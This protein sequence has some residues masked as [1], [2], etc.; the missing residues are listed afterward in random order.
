MAGPPSAPTAAVANWSLAASP[1]CTAPGYGAGAFVGPL[2]LS[3]GF[4]GGVIPAGWSVET[5]SGA[6]WKV[7]TGVEPCSIE[8]RTGG[9]GPYAMVNSGCEGPADTFLVTPT[10][11]LSGRTSAAIQWANDYITD[12]FEPS[13]VSVDVSDDGGSNWTNVWTRESNVPGPGHQIADMSFAAGHANVA[14]RFHYQGFFSRTWQVDDVKV[15]SSRA[16]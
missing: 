8:N 3:E 12:Q 14:V 15:G 5:V 4:D 7:Y 2:A 11:D 9:S 13:V 10:M 6:S 16:P 1:T